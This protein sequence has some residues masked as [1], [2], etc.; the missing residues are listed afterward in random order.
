MDGD[1]VCIVSHAFTELPQ[2]FLQVCV[3]SIFLYPFYF[4]SIK[5]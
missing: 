5:K 1:P 3:N 4:P 2:Y